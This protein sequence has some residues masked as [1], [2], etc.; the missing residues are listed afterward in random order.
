MSN[1]DGAEDSAPNGNVIPLRPRQATPESGGSEAEAL[2]A[3]RGALDDLRRKIRARS[4]GLAAE[5]APRPQSDPVDW[6]G[7][8]DELR[9]R[10]AR[11]GLR[12]RTG[13][14]DEFGME[15]DLVERMR[16]LREFMAKRYWRV[17]MRATEFVPRAGPAIYVANRSGLLPYDGWIFADL[18]RSAREGTE[19]PRFMVDEAL[20]TLP[21]LQPALTRM[22]GVLACPENARRLLAAGQSVVIF[23]EG[24]RGAIKTFDQRYRLQGFGHRWLAAV[25]AEAGVPVIPAGIVG[26]EE[27]QPMLFRSYGPAWLL[28]LPFLPV[29]PT[30]PWLGPLGLLPL[31]STWRVGF[32]RPLEPGSPDFEDP[33]GLDS[34]AF[35]GVLRDRVESLVE[36]GRRQRISPWS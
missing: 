31:P 32:G 28:G 30:F 23:P 22:G 7:L 21:F 8:F 5:E 15:T 33:A 29:T 35:I 3:L 17:A 19:A 20:I 13:E 36:T 24:M 10:L 34:D 27:A 6:F 16:P 9:T 12:E 26:A 2:E 4:P 11:A 14:I 18:V 25:A 1:S